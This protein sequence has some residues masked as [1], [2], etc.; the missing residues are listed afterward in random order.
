MSLG[1][2]LGPGTRRLAGLA[3][4]DNEDRINSITGGHRIEGN[5]FRESSNGIRGNGRSSDP[6]VIRG[7]TSIN[8][9]HAVGFAGSHV[10]L[11]DNDI[12]VPEPERVPGGQ[13]GLDNMEGPGSRRVS[14]VSAPTSGGARATCDT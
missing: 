3:A 4:G 5:T 2:A 13:P 14:W 10:H 1:L 6:I 12:S 9:Y 8:M 7:N 11:L